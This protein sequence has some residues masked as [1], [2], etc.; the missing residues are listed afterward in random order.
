MCVVFFS[1]ADMNFRGTEVLDTRSHSCFENS[2]CLLSDN[3]GDRVLSGQVASPIVDH[4]SDTADESNQSKS[5]HRIWIVSV[6]GNRSW[7]HNKRTNPSVA[8][9]ISPVGGS[10][11]RDVPPYKFKGQKARSQNG[12]GMEENGPEAWRT[13]S[14]RPPGQ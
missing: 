3:I 10:H 12:A 6:S 1:P 5:E 9:A 7:K 8:Y 11:P 13:D 4:Q 2:V 14:G